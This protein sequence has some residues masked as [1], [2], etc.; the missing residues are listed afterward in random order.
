M[1][2]SMQFRRTPQFSARCPERRVQP[3]RAIRRV[4]CHNMCRP[5]R[6]TREL[7]VEVTVGVN[8]SSP[9]DRTSDAMPGPPLTF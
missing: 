9:S 1:H 5:I 8:Q 2:I 3:H 6:V 4:L 7:D